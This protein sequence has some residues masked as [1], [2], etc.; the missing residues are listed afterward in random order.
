LGLPNRSYSLAFG[1]NSTTGMAD[2]EI[3]VALKH[4]R[5]KSTPEYMA[6][7]RRELPRRFPELTFY[8]QSADIV[9]QILNFGIPSPIDIQ[10][11]GTDRK[12]NL[13]TA[14]KIVDEV[15]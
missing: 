2:G 12:H 8:F 11:S 7:L 15:K 4:H 3:L 1:D 6:E 14:T 9:S 13:E 5:T 10:V